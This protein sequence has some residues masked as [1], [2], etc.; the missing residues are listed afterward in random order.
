MIDKLDLRIPRLSGFRPAV[1]SYINI[2][3]H[4]S[5]LSRVRP[6]QHYA[7]RVDLRAIGID[8]ILHIDCKHGDRH[9]KLEIL[10]IGNKPHSKMVRLI[11]SVTYADVE[12]MG[13]MRIDLTA[14][15]RD[16]TVPWLKDHMRFKFKRSERVYGEIK[17]SLIGKGEVETIQAGNRPNL[18]RVYN[19]TKESLVQFRQM[20]RKASKDADALEFEQE[21]G[22]KMT[23]VRTR[24][25]RQCGGNRIPDEIAT[26]GTLQNAPDFNPFSSLEIISARAITLPSPEECDGLEY[27]TG[28][29]MYNEV[30][31][32]GMQAFR[33]R[34][35]KLTTGNAARTIKRFHRFFP[36]GDGPNIT[37]ENL[38]AEYR[39]STIAQLSA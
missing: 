26:F 37:M 25:E 6:S 17:Y 5:F 23:D 34:L 10:N 39:E 36:G 28:V 33:K 30:A 38:L 13:I 22:F 24:V 11:E 1:A 4:F 2:H 20:E 3:P 8:A 32:D 21:F 29:G 35:N 12:T 19:K 18:Y 9:S 27:Y 15:V 7:G 31:R 16:V 14:D